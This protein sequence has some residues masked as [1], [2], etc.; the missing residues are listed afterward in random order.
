MRAGLTRR[1][2]LGGAVASLASAAFAQE[3]L[4]PRPRPASVVVAPPAPVGLGELRPV[5]RVEFDDLVARAGLEGKVSV[6]LVDLDAG[7]VEMAFDEGLALPPASTAK[8]L[9]ALYALEFL[10]AGH[11]FATRLLATGP[12]EGGKL[13]GELILAGGG[14][15]V[16]VT[17]R[18]AELA[19]R[20]A[21]SGIREV[22]GFR[23]WGAALPQLREITPEQ[24][25]WV[26]YNP[27]VGGL[28]LNFNRV[29]FQWER[30]GSDY[31]VRVEALGDNHRPDVRIASV[32][33]EARNLPAYTYAQDGDRDRWTVARGQL[34]G[35]GSRWLPVRS[36][37]LYTGE[38]FVGL[39]NEAGIAL[40]APTRIEA[41]PAG[42]TEIARIESDRLEDIAREMLLYS[43][44]PTA[45][46]LGLAAS[47]VRGVGPLSLAE[48]AG[49]M[50]DWIRETTG[51]QVALV[52]HSGLGGESRVAAGEMVKA[53]AGPRVRERL[54]PILKRI[55]LTN[56]GGDALAA[57]PGEVRA[58]TGT[59]NFA[60]SLAG[61]VRTLDGSDLAFAYVS[62]DV[63]ARREAADS[64]DEI[65]AGSREFL[66]RSRRLQQV[67][68]QRWGRLSV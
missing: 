12:V 38:A 36:P 21:A 7:G 46:V 62:A 53:L 10:G 8:A 29:H 63:E 40:P 13:R 27:S 48:S 41:L 56:A 52:D 55:T 15:P 4:R 61:Y 1:G 26:G 32:R 18:L 3:R 6:A 33:V 11:R 64:D 39:A 22:E 17:D 68:L 44:N 65:P 60:T 2:L 50:N 49:A 57:P 47:V 31:R 66:A 58:K 67:L 34:G 42:T 43:T 19:R 23:V 14:D 25:P 51:A 54:W 16:L 24:L 20:L 59:L 5:P 35:G 45:E 28:N 37:D 9:T 30:A